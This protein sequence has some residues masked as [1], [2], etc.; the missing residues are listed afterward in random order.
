MHCW[1]HTVQHNGRKRWFLLIYFVIVL[2]LLLNIIAFLLSLNFKIS[3]TCVHPIKKLLF[4]GCHYEVLLIFYRMIWKLILKIIEL[5]FI[6]K[7]LQDLNQSWK[8][9]K[10]PTKAYFTFF[11]IKMDVTKKGFCLF[12]AKFT[13]LVNH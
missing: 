2:F 5:K 4:K 7:T 6:L 11:K 8:T 1:M 13:F 3:C 9:W 12:Y 10:T